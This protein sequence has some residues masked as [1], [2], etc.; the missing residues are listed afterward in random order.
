MGNDKCFVPAENLPFRLIEIPIGSAPPYE[1][2][3]SIRTYDKHYF[4]CNDRQIE[5]S[6]FEGYDAPPSLLPPPTIP[7]RYDEPILILPERS[8]LYKFNSNKILSKSSSIKKNHHHRRKIF[9][10]KLTC[11]V[12]S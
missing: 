9:K 6:N 2:H 3:Q 12:I 1:E 10:T 8:D 7:K 4:Q 11:C 5:M